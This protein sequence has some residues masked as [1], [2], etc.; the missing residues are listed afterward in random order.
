MQASQVS[1][2]VKRWLNFWVRTVGGEEGGPTWVSW[3]PETIAEND[4]KVDL[5]KEILKYD[6]I[7]GD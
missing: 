6:H 3:Y 5:N 1:R 7:S 2:M 4:G